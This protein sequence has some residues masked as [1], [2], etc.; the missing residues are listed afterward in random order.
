[1]LQ[2]RQNTLFKSNQSQ[3]FK[4]LSGK[5]KTDNPSPDAAKAKAFWSGIWSERKVHNSKAKWLGEVKG[6]MKEK[7]R[8]MADN[9]VKI[10]DVIKKVKGISNWKAPWPDGVQGYWFKVFDCLHKPI[11]N[12]L[13]KCIVEGDV[14]V[15][16]VT[17]RTV[18]TQKDP[19][20][21]TKGSN[22]RPIACLPLMWKLLSGIFANRVYT[23]L[24]DNQ[25]P[26]EQKGARKK[27]RGTKDQLLIDKTILKEV[28]RLKKNVVMSWID[29]KKAY[30]ITP[31]SWFRETLNITGVAKNIQHL[32]NSLEEWGTLLS[33]NGNELGRLTSGEVYFRATHFLHYYL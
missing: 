2:H 7:V 12:A 32:T 18:L 13:Q 11:V 16:M 25:L 28:K 6:E 17:G 15:W 22:Y 19:T 33:S 3:V 8:G 20:K 23:H 10:E 26:E 14:L 4:E 30:D 29:Y 1:M 31:H 27:L 9:V 5:T 24:L 21:G